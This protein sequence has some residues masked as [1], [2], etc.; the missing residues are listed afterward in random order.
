MIRIKN[1]VVL[2]VLLSKNYHPLLIELILDIYSVVSEV[3]VTEGWREGGGVH[4]TDP[5]RGIDLRS[6]IYTPDK[7][8]KIESYINSKW[9]YDPNRPDMKCL[10]LHGDRGQRHIHVQVHPNTVKR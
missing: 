9:T 6:W 3:V 1:T 4:S 8:K 10:I 2:K 5:C 7:Q